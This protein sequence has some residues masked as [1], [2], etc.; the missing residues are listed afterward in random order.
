MG[1]FCVE[2]GGAG[3]KY[4][5]WNSPRMDQ[6][7]IT[8]LLTIGALPFLCLSF[9][10]MSLKVKTQYLTIKRKVSSLKNEYHDSP[11][12]HQ[13]LVQYMPYPFHCHGAL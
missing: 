3:K 5:M 6:K 1:S 8:C 4:V 2:T 13:I 11:T 7:R 10:V 12:I 9:Q